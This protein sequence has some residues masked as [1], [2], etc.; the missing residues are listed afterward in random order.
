M[1]LRFYIVFHILKLAIL[2]NLVE[3]KV[4]QDSSLK[5]RM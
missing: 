3:L 1:K 2:L 4:E 5:L